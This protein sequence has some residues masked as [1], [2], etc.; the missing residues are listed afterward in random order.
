MAGVTDLL[1]VVPFRNAWPWLGACLGSIAVQDHPAKTVVVVDDASDDGYSGLLAAWCRAEGWVYIS[2]LMSV[3]M[4]RTL[5]QAVNTV[6][7]DSDQVVVIID[8]DDWL[9][10]RHV[11]SDLASAFD[12]PGLWLTWG[13]YTRWPDP[14]YQPNPAAPYPT[15]VAE[16]NGYRHHDYAAFNHPLAFRRHL[17]EQ[18][19]DTD[20]QDDR[21]EWMTV[22]YDQMIMYPMLELSGPDHQRFLPE[23]LYVYNEQNPL[24][25]TRTRTDGMDVKSMLSGRPPR[26]RL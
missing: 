16:A 11:L 6:P 19:T 8:G 18:V 24:S 21:G 7:G 2:N 14:A 26:G 1:V 17:W 15:E 12:D 10:H 4:P 3:K 5:R 13:S 9:P 23:T 25:E 22:A 20:L